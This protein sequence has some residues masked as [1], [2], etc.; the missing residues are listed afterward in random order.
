M[1][2]S[3]TTAPAPKSQST[4]K[5]A[6][7]VGTSPTFADETPKVEAHLIGFAGDLYGQELRVEFLAR[8]RETRAFAGPGDLVEQLRRDVEAARGVAAGRV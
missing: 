8:L 6:V 7:N 2:S 3:T 1:K 5:P 4:G